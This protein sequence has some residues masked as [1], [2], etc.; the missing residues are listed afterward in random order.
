MTMII[1]RQQL[2]I[3][4]PITFLLQEP[5]NR[6]VRRDR[7]VSGLLESHQRSNLDNFIIFHTFSRWKEHFNSKHNL[8]DLDDDFL[9]FHFDMK[10]HQ[11][12]VINRLEQ[13]KK[14]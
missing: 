5:L 4:D 1:R 6:V 7:K 14:C 8:P 2:F 9:K 13:N 12:T 3:A 10:F 11:A